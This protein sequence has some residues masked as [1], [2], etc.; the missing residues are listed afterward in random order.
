VLCYKFYLSVLDMGL[1]RNKLKD[2]ALSFVMVVIYFG[3]WII[4]SVI[5]RPVHRVLLFVM[6]RVMR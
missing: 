3:T 6:M 2:Q 5:P 4:P 1:F